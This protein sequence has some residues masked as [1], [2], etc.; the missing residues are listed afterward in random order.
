MAAAP[1]IGINNRTP[2]AGEIVTVRAMVVHPM[3]TG[4]RKRATGELIPRKIINKFTCT[5]NG[6]PLVTWNLETSVSV[7]PYVDFRFRA[8]ESGELKLTWVDDD[9]VTIE[10]I[11]KITVG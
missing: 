6:K 5:L 11:E 3:E 1:R 9:N 8:T 2:K 7:N 10:A 4:L